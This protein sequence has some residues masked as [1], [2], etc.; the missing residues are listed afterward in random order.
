MNQSS[1][2]YRLQQVDSQLDHAHKRIDEIDKTLSQDEELQQAQQ[3]LAAAQGKVKEEQKLLRHAEEAVQDLKIKIEQTEAM[4]YGGKVRNPKE[5]QDLQAE[6]ASLKKHLII[7][8]D[9]ELEAMLDLDN[10]EQQMTTATQSLSTVQTRLSS[11][12]AL[13]NGERLSITDQVHRLE[14]EREVAITMIGAED[15]AV[16]EQLRIQRRGIAVA[17]AVD[18]SCSAC[19]S[20]LTPS[21]IQ[22]AVTSPVLVRCPTCSRIIYPG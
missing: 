17:K 6:A 16:Y 10:A 22:Q 11:Q 15:L 3:A 13:L 2:L 19:G 1:N 18:K 4:L 9:R 7:L 14:T 12:F 21:L 5:L 8:E 20:A